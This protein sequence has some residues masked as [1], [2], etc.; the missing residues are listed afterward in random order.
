M[1][2]LYRRQATTELR[3]WISLLCMTI[4]CATSSRVGWVSM[5]KILMFS[6][7]QN[8]NEISGPKQS[9]NISDRLAWISTNVNDCIICTLCTEIYM[10]ETGRKLAHRFREHFRDVEEGD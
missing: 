3:F 6:W 10:G 5:F 4:I 9:I 2:P 8:A 7:I 1:L